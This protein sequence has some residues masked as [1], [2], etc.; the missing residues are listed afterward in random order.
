MKPWINKHISVCSVTLGFSFPKERKKQFTKP[1]EECWQ[2]TGNKHF[3]EALKIQDMCLYLKNLWFLVSYLLLWR[4]M[5]SRYS[6]KDMVAKC[7]NPAFGQRGLY[8]PCIQDIPVLTCK[9]VSRNK[10]LIREV[11][12]YWKMLNSWNTFVKKQR[13]EKERI[14]SLWR[15]SVK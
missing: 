12:T 13:Q 1:K 11:V 2:M 3:S 8:N 5:S 7:I 15:M 6:Q 10:D 9:N 4:C 14:N